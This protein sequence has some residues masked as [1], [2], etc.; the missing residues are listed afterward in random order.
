MLTSALLAAVIGVTLPGDGLLDYDTRWD[1]PHYL[2]ARPGD[3]QIVDTNP[4][5]M[6]WPYVQGTTVDGHPEQRLFTLQIAADDSFAD[7]VVEVIDTPYNFY[8]ALPVLDEGEWYWRVGYR[9]ADEEDVRWSDTRSFVITPQAVEWDRTIITRAHEVLAQKSHPRMGPADGDWAAFRAAL[10][11]DP[12]GAEY[13]G[14]V[15]RLADADR[16]DW[17][18]DF[19][20]TDVKE[21]T[22]LAGRDWITITR[23]LAQAAMAWRL[24]GDERLLPAKEHMLTLASFPKGG[25]TSPEYHAQVRKWPTQINQHLAVCYDLWYPDLTDQERAAVREAIEWRLEATYLEAKSWA[26]A[27]GTVDWR[28]VAVFAASHPYENFVWSLPA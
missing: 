3:G 4:P 6:S 9:L 21:D 18:D 23:Y 22:G 5:R 20:Q 7:A 19:P 10:E 14:S 15:L 1:Y 27:D 2:N 25:Q 28:G 26:R 16:P 24:T 11:A 13:V 8:N 12:R 17:W